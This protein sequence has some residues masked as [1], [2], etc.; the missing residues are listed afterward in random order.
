MREQ[1]YKGENREEENQIS[2][3]DRGATDLSMPSSSASTHTQNALQSYDLFLVLD[4][5]ATCQ[6]RA[7][8]NYPNEIIASVSKLHPRP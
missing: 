3:G 6:E 8:M 1:D 7:G 4:V 2:T 5:E